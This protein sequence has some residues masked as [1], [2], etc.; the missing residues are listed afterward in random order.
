M[1]G[2]TF[3]KKH[4]GYGYTTI[5]RKPGKQNMQ[6]SKNKTGSSGKMNMV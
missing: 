4:A 5:Q 2:M 6:F 3:L 1:Q